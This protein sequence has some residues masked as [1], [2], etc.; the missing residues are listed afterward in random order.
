MY[1]GPGGHNEGVWK[2]ASS[3]KK[4]ME[5]KNLPCQTIHL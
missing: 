4:F 3:V 5:E 1:T 2:M